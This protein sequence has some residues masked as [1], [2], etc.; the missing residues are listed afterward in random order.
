MAAAQRGE[1]A[2][3]TS[4][5]RSSLLTIRASPHR[6][7]EAL[8]ASADALPP[9]LGAGG[10]EKSFP[11]S[12]HYSLP[13][14]AVVHLDVEYRQRLHSLI[15]A[16]SLSQLQSALLRAL[17]QQAVLRFNQSTASLLRSFLPFTFRPSSPSTPTAAE[18][19]SDPAPF[20][21]EPLA[22][23]RPALQPFVRDFL[24]ETE[25]AFQETARFALTEQLDHVA[26]FI[27]AQQRSAAPAHDHEGREES[28]GHARVEAER[29]VSGVQ[30]ALAR[31]LHQVVQHADRSQLMAMA[32]A[33][34]SFRTSTAATPIRPPAQSPSSAS[35]AEA[36]A[37]PT[38]SPAAIEGV[39][40]STTP[41]DAAR[42][43]ADDVLCSGGL[44]P[45]CLVLSYLSFSDLARSTAVV[46]R[47][48]FSASH[49]PLCWRLLHSLHFFSCPPPPLLS[50]SLHK[51]LQLRHLSFPRSALDEHVAAIAREDSTD[52]FG[53]YLSSQQPFPLTPFLTHLTSINLS[54]CAHLTD[55]AFLAL[56]KRSTSQHE[57][58]AL[59]VLGHLEH[60]SLSGCSALT[61]AAFLA[62]FPYLP[63]LLSLDVSNIGRIGLPSFTALSLHCTRLT[64]LDLSSCR[65][66]NDAIIKQIASSL[67][68]LRSLSVASC[69]ALST[70]ALSLLSTHCPH[71]TALDLSACQSAVTDVSIRSLALA[72]HDLRRLTLK[73]C[74]VT[75]SGLDLLLRGCRRMEALDLGE[76]TWGGSVRADFSDRTLVSLSKFTRGLTSLVLTSSASITDRGVLTLGQSC[77]QLTSLTFTQCGQ[78]TSLALVYLGDSPAA[79]TLT[80]LT[81]SLCH[82]IDDHGTSYALN[83]CSR[84]VT[85]RTAQCVGVTDRTLQFLGRRAA[86]AMGESSSS[87]S[88][89]AVRDLDVFRCPISDRG[90]LGLLRAKD[91]R[92][93]GLQSLLLGNCRVSDEGVAAVAST[94][95]RM[96]HLSL[97]GCASITDASLTALS[98]HCSQPHRRRNPSRRAPTL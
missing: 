2:P 24:R 33:F 26:A 36:K 32:D 80:S 97:Y 27:D 78:L 50:L 95:P 72:C 70:A 52:L 60:L 62:L 87:S 79:S 42:P 77:P 13:P 17:E 45:L 18:A 16:A 69:W 6:P 89:C 29:A 61:D 10:A 47:H 57:N 83:K 41:C 58:P 4:S 28:N 35:A 37:H 82:R 56:A 92:W 9:A 91:G 49:S 48:F 14:A 65:S 84:L 54:H 39:A 94:C 71:I 55:A 44:E 98:Q 74:A 11:P 31:W 59:P 38:P 3:A 19:Q 22:D 66:V 43:A 8:S 23:L 12:S 63:S 73:G 7:A 46:S 96:R 64:S 5:P 68:S 85:L 15:P 67:P 40:A 25:R 90:L 21:A 51:A 1:D 76:S 88:A 75:D 53:S 30:R 86:R 34:D 93:E 81:V 20:A